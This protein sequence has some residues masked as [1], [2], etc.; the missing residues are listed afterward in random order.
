MRKQVFSNF[1]RVSTIRSCIIQ[2]LF[3]VITTLCLWTY[4][5][6]MDHLWWTSTLKRGPHLVN[7]PSP[8]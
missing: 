8:C 7:G 3:H 4:G 6:K 2:G 1:D 5:D